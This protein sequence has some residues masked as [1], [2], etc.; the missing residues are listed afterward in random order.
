MRTS[1]S[2]WQYRIG[3]FLPFSQGAPP[4][5]DLAETDTIIA[6]SW[7]RPEIP[8]AKLG[9]FINYCLEKADGD[10]FNAIL[11]LA[12]KKVKPGTTN[13]AMAKIVKQLADTG[14]QRHLILQWEI[15]LGLYLMDKCWFN[16]NFYHIHVLW[17]RGKYYGAVH[18][19]EDA[20]QIMKKFDLKRPLL[21]AHQVM[22]RR[23]VGIAWKQGISVV[24]KPFTIPHD[25]ASWPIQKWTAYPILS[26]LRD[27][28][29]R[30]DHLTRHHWVSLT[31]PSS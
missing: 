7:G 3:Y 31:P 24:V 25:P 2:V 12:E 28:L 1:L 10:S 29:A 13:L 21:L 23:A 30:I 9:T 5:G 16:R 20:L 4:F 19:I 8:D 22:I 6:Q 14:R 11:L 26:H 18:V 17:P 27:F 15:A